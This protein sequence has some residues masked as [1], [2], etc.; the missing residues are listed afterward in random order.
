MQALACLCNEAW[1]RQRTGKFDAV[2]KL[3]VLGDLRT[4]TAAVLIVQQRRSQS[5]ADRRKTIQHD[6]RC[7]L[8]CRWQ[9][10]ARVC[11]APGS[12]SCTCQMWPGWSPPRSACL[13]QAM[14]RRQMVSNSFP[15]SQAQLTV[16]DM[17]CLH[18]VVAVGGVVGHAAED[19]LGEAAPPAEAC[20]AIQAERVRTGTCVCCAALEQGAQRA[21]RT[22]YPSQRR[23]A[24]AHSGVSCPLCQLQSVSC[25]GQPDPVR[26]IKIALTVRNGGSAIVD[27]CLRQSCKESAGRQQRCA[28][29]HTTVCSTYRSTRREQLCTHDR[30]AP[31]FLPTRRCCHYTQ[32]RAD[33]RNSEKL[34]TFSHVTVASTGGPVLQI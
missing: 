12:G 22:A 28:R 34:A 10:A 3:C 30:P 14:R 21:A 17:Q 5:R 33:Q 13:Q 9:A 4:G 18:L 20:V 2:V 31:H 11:Q 27:V 19:E 16:L 6:V 24:E 8:P 32:E 23:P 26:I 7:H 29:A 15:A 1:Q 25:P